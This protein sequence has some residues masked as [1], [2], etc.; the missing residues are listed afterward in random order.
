MSHLECPTQYILLEVESSKHKHCY[1]DFHANVTPHEV[2]LANE[3]IQLHLVDGMAMVKKLPTE[4]VE[5]ATVTKRALILS[6]DSFWNLATPL[7]SSSST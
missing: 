4:M 7:K 1:K 5:L 2:C 3:K 6:L